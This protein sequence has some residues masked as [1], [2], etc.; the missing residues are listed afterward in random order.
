MRR[1]MLTVP[2]A[3]GIRPRLSSGSPN[4]ASGLRLH[5]SAVG[6]HLQPAAQH[7]AVHLG[8]AVA[9]EAGGQL[10]EHQR[11]A[12][13]GAGQMRA[14]RVGECAEL[15]EVTAAAEGRAVAG[16]HH[17][18]DGRVETGDLERLEQGG[19]RIGG[20]RVVPLRAG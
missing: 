3:P 19:A 5:P 17:L 20:E 18:V 8:A 11:R 15:G 14:G 13:P 1:V 7:L 12:V 10:V 4:T 9:A 16:Q 6:G 2:P